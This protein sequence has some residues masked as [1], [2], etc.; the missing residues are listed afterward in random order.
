M[1]PRARTPWR[2]LLLLASIF[3]AGLLCGAGGTSAIILHHL[4]AA[5]RDAGSARHGELL[6]RRLEERMQK[7][8]DLTPPQRNAVA[9]E[10]QVTVMEL[11]ELRSDATSRARAIAAD[12]LQRLEASL[13]PAKAPR[14]REIFE[15][16]LSPWG[17]H[18]E[19]STE[20]KE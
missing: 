19:P 16:R 1:S 13:P 8:L 10:F 2:A 17:L 14:L 15:E 11:R 9:R 12:T 5:A 20:T 4:Q 7:D 3:V 6:V 18:P